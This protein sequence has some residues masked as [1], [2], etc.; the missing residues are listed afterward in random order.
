MPYIKQQVI[1][2][3]EFSQPTTA[4]DT[5][6][7]AMIV[8]PNANLHRYSDATEKA[9]ILLP[10]EYD[11]EKERTYLYPERTA[12]GV[13]DK[14][15]SKLY[16]DDALLSYYEDM[17]QATKESGATVDVQSAVDQANLVKTNINLISNGSAHPRYSGFGSRDVQ[18][19]D[20]AW[21]QAYVG[22]GTESDGC[23]YYE[24]LSKII[25][26][27]PEEEPATIGHQLQLS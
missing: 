3:Q 6:L 10:N 7:R 11:P 9:E 2:H 22:N 14:D 15:Y 19:G 20:Y 21:L 23:K 27:A 26:F 24:H 18:I 4:D 13:V 16:V 8:G 12:G 17:T 1:I 5:T 25:G